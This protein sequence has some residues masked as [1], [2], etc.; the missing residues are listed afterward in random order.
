MPTRDTH[1]SGYLTPSQLGL[2]DVLLVET[3]PFF[4]N[5]SLF[6][7]DYALGSSL[8]IFSVLLSCILEV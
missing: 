5:L 1:S 6:C 3:N 2:A 7:P 4:P 8:G